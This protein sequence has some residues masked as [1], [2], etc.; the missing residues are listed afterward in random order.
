MEKRFRTLV[1]A[2]AICSSTICFAADPQAQISAREQSFKNAWDKRDA[3]AMA[4]IITPDFLMIT[5]AGGAIA[6]KQFLDGLASGAYS[7]RE[8]ESSFPKPKDL[9]IRFYGADT[10]VVTYSQERPWTP[11]GGKQ[12][13]AVHF[14]THVW[15]NPDG[16]GWRIASRHVSIPTERERRAS[17]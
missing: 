8:L 6:R 9:L 1:A 11:K 3:G 4:D 10:A 5:R 17:E 2:V 12:V 14:F 7:T 15:V 16:K 13:Q